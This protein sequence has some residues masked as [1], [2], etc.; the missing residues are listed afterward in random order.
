M[1]NNSEFISAGRIR[2]K[3]NEVLLLFSFLA[4]AF[5]FIPVIGFAQ[6][7]QNDWFYNPFNQYSAHH[8]P[9]GTGAIY[10]DEDHPAVQDW[11]QG[12]QM[13]INVG[14]RP[15]GLF[16]IDAD[17]SGP[18]LTV[19]KRQ[20]TGTSGLPVVMRFPAGGVDIDFPSHFDGN[21]TVYDRT[22]DVWNH[23][24][25]YAW[26]EG[27]PVAMQYRSYEHNSI[28]HGEELA[29]RVGTSASGVAA[30]FGILRGWEV[31]KTGHPIGH[32]LQMVLPR[33][34]SHFAMMLGREVW[35]PAVGMD[36]NAYTTEENNTGNIPYGSLWAI[37]PESKGGP[38]LDTLGLTERGKR[39]AEALR[40]YG[41]YAV[42]GGAAVAIRC[43][44]NF[45]EALRLELVNETRKFYPYLRMVLN[46][47]PDEGKV[48]FNVG[49]RG[50]APSGPVKQ[51]IRGEF[52]AGG[53]TPLA[54]NTAIDLVTSSSSYNTVKANLFETVRLFPNPAI[55]RVTITYN[56]NYGPVSV[57]VLN[58][59]GQVVRTKSSLYSGA[60]LIL[61]DE[62]DIYFIRLISNR[63][64]GTYR[65]LKL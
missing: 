29:K 44:Q 45:S 40:D 58:V 2:Q 48:V 26:N 17:E 1:I 31:K 46:S 24:R 39:L 43:D 12:S 63:G 34:P 27:N 3:V 61:P 16:M 25:V 38:D 20:E 23:L 30:P 21:I 52:P 10:A 13:N 5:I 37:P 19:N 50:W 28:G 56:E 18:M 57:E 51:V 64:T 11:L 8:R 65:V 22:I 14:D 60:N 53:G 4:L 42:D 54:P 6:D 33:L 49:D 9:I 55:D 41:I 59:L 32:A 62:Q 7:Y 35:W 47:V 36:G 15:H